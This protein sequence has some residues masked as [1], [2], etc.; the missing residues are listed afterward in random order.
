MNVS[1]YNTENLYIIYSMQR[2]KVEIFDL[3]EIA[4]SKRLS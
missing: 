3:V 2:R 4:S 1:A